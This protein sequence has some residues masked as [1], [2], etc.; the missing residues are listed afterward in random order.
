MALSPIHLHTYDGLTRGNFNFYFA[1]F[2]ITHANTFAFRKKILE[3]NAIR[4]KL[5]HFLTIH[6]VAL[7]YTVNLYTL[8]SKLKKCPTKYLLVIMT[9]FYMK[10]PTVS[11][12]AT[13][14]AYA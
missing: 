7:F 4:S 3:S 10:W 8:L 12:L 2:S 11:K 6:Q 13:I 1:K 9:T 14:L 5:L